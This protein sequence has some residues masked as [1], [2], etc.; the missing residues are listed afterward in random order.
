MDDLTKLTGGECWSAKGYGLSG[1]KG[2]VSRRYRTDWL[3]ALLHLARRKRNV[4]YKCC[5]P[6]V[7]TYDYHYICIRVKTQAL[8]EMAPVGA[9]L[10]R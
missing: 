2:I 3:K 4:T 8:T 9:S 10:P 1:K 6:P 5:A 7:N